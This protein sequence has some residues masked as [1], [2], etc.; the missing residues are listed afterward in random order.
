MRLSLNLSLPM[1]LVKGGP[2]Y[3]VFGPVEKESRT[4]AKE[5]ELSD[6]V[7][8]FPLENFA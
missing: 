4:V 1:S 3:A 2:P 6:L 7:E 8:I 5:L